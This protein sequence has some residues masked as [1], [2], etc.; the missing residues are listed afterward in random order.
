MAVSNTQ[1]L[2]NPRTGQ[3]TV[4]PAG[5]AQAASLIQQGY[6]GSPPA[7]AP[8]PVSQPIVQPVSQS[9][10]SGVPLNLPGAYMLPGASASTPWAYGSPLPAGA[11]PIY[12]PKTIQVAGPLSPTYYTPTPT[13]YQVIPT[14]LSAPSPAP[15]APT[16]MPTPLN[17]M[18]AYTGALQPVGTLQGGVVPT[19]TPTY[20]PYTPTTPTPQPAPTPTPAGSLGQPSPQGVAL[21]NIPGLPSPILMP[22]SQAK[23]SGLSYQVITPTPQQLATAIPTLTNQQ[24]AINALAPYKTADNK[25][26]LMTIAQAIR[27]NPAL[28]KSAM[29]AF[30]DQDW[31]YLEYAAKPEIA[32]DL[33]MKLKPS[34]QD[35]YRPVRQAT[36][37]NEYARLLGE[38]Q[39]NDPIVAMNAKWQL[40]SIS[41]VGRAKVSPDVYAALGATGKAYTEPYVGGIRGDIAKVLTAWETE[42]ASLPAISQYI[43]SAGEFGLAVLVPGVGMPLLAVSAVAPTLGRSIIG[44]KP[45]VMEIA[46]DTAMVA[47]AT[48]AHTAPTITNRLPG[49]AGK[50]TIGTVQGAA[51]GTF[52]TNIGLNWDNMSPGDK[53]LN[54]GMMVAIPLGKAAKSGFDTVNKQITTLTTKGG[55]LPAALKVGKMDVAYVEVP[56]IFKGYEGRIA[57]IIRTESPKNQTSAIRA[58]LNPE[59]Q[60]KFDQYIKLG[61]EISSLKIPD[62]LVNKTVD[63]S[64]VEAI[65]GKSDV[66][67]AIKGFLQNNARDIYTY[68]STARVQQLEGIG[69]KVPGD[70]D[71]LIKSNSRM[72][73]SQVAQKLGEYIQSNT[74]GHSI[75]VNGAKIKVDGIDIS[76]IH[77]EGYAGKNPFGWPTTMEPVIIDGVAFGDIRALLYDL[78]KPPT[79]PGIGKAAG[80]L[81]PEVAEPFPRGR[82][83]ETVFGTIPERAKDITAFN[84]AMK[85]IADSITTTQPELSK[86]IINSLY[87][88]QTT[89]TGKPLPILADTEAKARFL[90]MVAKVQQQ[91][92]EK[93]I[94]A[95]ITDPQ[96]GT[97]LMRVASPASQVEQGL[98]YHATRDYTPYL[99]SSKEQGYVEIGKLLGNEKAMREQL[100]T[101]PDAAFDRLLEIGGGTLPE[102][103]AIIVLRTTPTDFKTALVGSPF[104]FELSSDGKPIVYDERVIPTGAKIYSTN[105]TDLSLSKTGISEGAIGETVTYYPRTKT[106]ISMLWFNT[107][108]AKVANFEVPTL[109]QIRAMNWLAFKSMVAS[110]AHPHIAKN[111]EFT[112]GD[113]KGVKGSLVEFYR[114]TFELKTKSPDEVRTIISKESTTLAKEAVDNLTSKGKLENISREK[115]QELIDEEVER[116]ITDRVDSVMKN[117]DV[118]KTLAKES[119]ESVASSYVINVRDL[120]TNMSK[121]ST[122]PI[123]T[124]STPT[125]SPTIKESIISGTV[126]SM[127]PS[128]IPITKPPSIM[129]ETVAPTPTEAIPPRIASPSLTTTPLPT[130]TIPPVETI[131]PPTETI[132][133]PTSLAITPP[134]TKI[135]PP[136]PTTITPPPTTP[137]KT[138]IITPTIETIT[139]PP[140]TPTETIT[141]TITPSITPPTRLRQTPPILLPIPIETKGK[142]IS[143]QRW[144]KKDGLVAWQQGSIRQGRN[145]EIVWH[146]YWFPYEEENQDTWVDN[147]P[148]EGAMVVDTHKAAQTIQLLKGTAPEGTKRV[149]VGAVNAL[150]TGT[151]GKE[152]SLRFEST[153]KQKGYTNASIR[154]SRKYAKAKVARQRK[155]ESGMQIW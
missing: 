88:I 60:V 103:A 44:Q 94:D 151:G 112:W 59:S 149:N 140:T 6:L 49:L 10:P 65:K 132:P 69:L 37:I 32:I 107:E 24:Q 102:K 144:Y 2:W 76:D 150:V 127:T 22:L 115:T 35:F 19:P 12:E 90:D 13:G 84:L 15:L 142:E 1:T 130:K 61:S 56:D 120:L 101:S 48:L 45:G 124:A 134:T 58:I 81:G 118:M 14:P 36:D 152:V 135:I 28:A 31:I 123:M 154:G 46:S 136:T 68:G 100:F 8:A 74:S 78:M 139:P 83:G 20:P 64:N 57:D 148:P 66:A 23:A 67:N 117:Q 92:L 29:T 33:W 125:I 147:T 141:T 11:T 51:I 97:T 119:G 50:A 54:I 39:S 133:P 21:V 129:L 113:T 122:L 55:I 4:V 106:P 155:V 63:F 72:T 47:L 40:A 96:S 43:I 105:P 89:P 71:F 42:K 38:S 34:A 41:G 5:G 79:T 138:T 17:I 27:D 7:N 95:T 121:I 145:L 109:T 52:A 108:S 153:K 85:G 30:P 73:P 98:L 75:E 137:I 62:T 91:V 104:R 126:E 26:N 18:G 70:F 99:S 9:S 53:V 77:I 114:D 93:G 110:L 80:L 82:I 128:E 25:Y 87:E 3:P 16:P 86:S 131:L 116:I 146:L 111:I 143:Q